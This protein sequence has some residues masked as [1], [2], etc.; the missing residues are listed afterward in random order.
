VFVPLFVGANSDEDDTFAEGRLREAFTLA[1][2]EHVDFEFEPVAAAHFYES[3]LDHDELILIG[4]FG[5]GTSDF[6]L[7]RVGP[8]ARMAAPADRLLGNGGADRGRRLTAGSCARPSRR[9]RLRQRVPLVFGR[10]LPVPKWIY[11]HGALAPS[12]VPAH[13]ADAGAPLRSAREALEPERFEALIHIVNEDLGFPLHRAVERAKPALTRGSTGELSFAHGPVKP[14]PR[15]LRARVRDLDCAGAGGDREVCRL[16]AQD[17]GLPAATSTAPV[18][19]AAERPGRGREQPT[20]ALF[21]DA[22]PE[23][24]ALPLEALAVLAL[25]SAAARSRAARAPSRSGR[26]SR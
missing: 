15:L 9:A 21:A 22:V 20:R 18:P 16:S 14:V 3:T 10:V 4:D 26:A 7:I 19:A 5:G 6:T 25:S 1:G 11:A 17:C 8:Q 13:A 12:V 24:A 23:P 2:F